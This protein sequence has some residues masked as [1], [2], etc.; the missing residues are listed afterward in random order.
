MRMIQKVRARHEREAW[1]KARQMAM[2][3]TSEMNVSIITGLFLFFGNIR[4]F[5]RQEVDVAGFLATETGSGEEGGDDVSEKGLPGLRV[6]GYAN[7]GGGKT[8]VFFRLEQVTDG[9]E[10]YSIVQRY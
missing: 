6:G 7:D 4:F 1:Q 10:L 8:V 3:L 5:F 2:A 9:A